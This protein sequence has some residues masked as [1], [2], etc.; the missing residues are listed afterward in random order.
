MIPTGI[1]EEVEDE[2]GVDAIAQEKTKK[3]SIEEKCY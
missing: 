2:V 1:P 3:T